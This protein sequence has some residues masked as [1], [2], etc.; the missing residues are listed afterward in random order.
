MKMDGI[1]PILDLKD[2]LFGMRD[3]HD[4]LMIKQQKISIGFIPNMVQKQ[5][6]SKQGNIDTIIIRDR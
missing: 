1:D 4:R 6:Y 3:N 2:L 5:G